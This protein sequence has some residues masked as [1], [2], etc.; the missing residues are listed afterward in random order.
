M[1][2]KPAIDKDPR[3]LL[4]DVGD[5]AMR[6]MAQM[7]E[8]AVS[9]MK[10]GLAPDAKGRIPYRDRREAAKYVL[11]YALPTSPNR[12]GLPEGTTVNILNADRESMM[13]FIQ[14]AGELER[15]PHELR[16]VRAVEDDPH[17]I[18]AGSRKPEDE[19]APGEGP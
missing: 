19:T 13:K 7:T 1:A 8:D 12:T 14:R 16:D 10:E 15:I 2:A 4:E 5:E 11:D 9:V 18:P 6:E 17:L 3:K